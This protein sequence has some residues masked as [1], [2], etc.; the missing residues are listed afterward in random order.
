MARLLPLHNLQNNNEGAAETVVIPK[1][2]VCPRNLLFL[3]FAKKSRSLGRRGDL[4]MTKSAFSAASEACARNTAE[5][6]SF[7]DLPANFQEGQEA[8]FGAS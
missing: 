7:L 8:P 6:N 4:G 5:W 2:G 3:G 1:G